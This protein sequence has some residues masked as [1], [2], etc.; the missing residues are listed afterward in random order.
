MTESNVPQG[1]KPGDEKPKG[2]PIK[3]IIAGV[4]ILGALIA[5]WAVPDI[6]TNSGLQDGVLESED[7]FADE[8]ILSPS[9]TP[10]PKP[11]LPPEREE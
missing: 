9:P 2:L 11:V 10:L 4:L 6:P 5:S 1:E 7:A 3:R 8:P